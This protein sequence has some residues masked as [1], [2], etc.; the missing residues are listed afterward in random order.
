MVPNLVAQPRTISATT[1]SRPV[2]SVVPDWY[3]HI[4]I[5]SDDAKNAAT[6]LLKAKGWLKSG[7]S[8]ADLDPAKAIELNSPRMRTT[9]LDAI[10]VEIERTGTSNKDQTNG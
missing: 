3:E 5:K 2:T 10:R 6:S 4:G 7:Q 9:F 8:L 1:P